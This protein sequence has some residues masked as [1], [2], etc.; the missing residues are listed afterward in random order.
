MQLTS[1]EVNPLVSEFPPQYPVAKFGLLINNCPTVQGLSTGCNLSSK[2]YAAEF[3]TG[4][5]I[6]TFICTKKYFIILWKS[7]EECELYSDL[8]YNS[9]NFLL[10]NAYLFVIVQLLVQIIDRSKYC[11]RC[12]GHFGWSVEIANLT[13]L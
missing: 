13:V 5:P 4:I 6:G 8:K 9:L 10:I 12:I 1:V 11:I 2:I 7:F 3:S